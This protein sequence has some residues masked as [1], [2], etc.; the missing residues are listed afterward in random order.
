MMVGQEFGAWSKAIARD[1]WRI[2]KVE[3]RLRQINI[4]GTAIG[5]GMNASH[6]FI[7]LMTDLLQDMTGLGL[8]GASSL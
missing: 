3:E 7:F 6:K 2:Y 8:A 1:R 4:G 5:T